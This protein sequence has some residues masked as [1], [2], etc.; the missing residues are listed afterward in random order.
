MSESQP[1]DILQTRSGVQAAVLAAETA[2]RTQEPDQLIAALQEVDRWLQALPTERVVDGSGA[3]D[4]ADE[5]AGERQQ[6]WL[7]RGRLLVMADKSEVVVQGLHSLDQAIAR[8]Q[9]A[10]GRADAQEA[11]VVAWMNRGS[12]LFR[13]GERESLSEGVRAYDQAINVLERLPGADRNVLGA[14]WMNRGVGLMH[15]ES[16]YEP[17][18]TLAARLADAAKSFDNAVAALEPLAVGGD[19]AAQRNLASAW[20]NLGILRGRLGDAAGALAAHRKAVD[21]F[22][23][24]AAE[25]GASGIF[26]LAARLFNLG[27]AC[28]ASG[29]TAEGVAAG[30]EA[31]ALAMQ[32]AEGNAQAGELVARA[33]HAICV[34]LGALISG[35][36]RD[37][38]ERAGRIAE[39]GDLVEDGLAALALRAGNA[40]DGE[41]AAGERLYEFGAW[42]Y[43]TQQ[44]QFLGEFLLEHLGEE[45]GRARIAAAAVQAA[46]QGLVQRDFNDTS[47]GDMNRVLDT[48]QDLGAVEAR[49][50][51]ILSRAMPVEPNRK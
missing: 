13:L 50:R 45:T 21:L 27:Q 30:R 3:P 40:T 41:K 12:G 1:L 34:A 10:G 19:E 29:D 17:K 15:L 48:L 23:P 51:E 5:L 22:R 49:Y 32:V 16:G 14:A 42:L 38:E 4:P 46:R 6:L 25:G 39:A 44:P 36:A 7:W 9:A 8:L 20:A 43:R 24:I 28:G 2:W 47:H 26:E 31:L 37:G 18:E 33:R 11:L 35:G